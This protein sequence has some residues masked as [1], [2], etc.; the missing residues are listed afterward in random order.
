V[1]IEDRP[2]QADIEGEEQTTD[3]RCIANMQLVI[4]AE[5]RKISS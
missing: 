2:N 4:D 3:R 1:L 5:I